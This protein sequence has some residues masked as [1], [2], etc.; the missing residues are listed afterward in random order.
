MY[1]NSDGSAT[2]PGRLW[3]AVLVSLFA[4]GIVVVIILPIVASTIRPALVAQLYSSLP[5]SEAAFIE[6]RYDFIIGILRF[7]PFLLLFGAIVYL[8][9]TLFQKERYDYYG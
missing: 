2:S 1:E 3:V 9:L 5:A 4:I 8:V 6:A 7:T